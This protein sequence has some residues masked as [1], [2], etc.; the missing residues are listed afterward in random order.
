VAKNSPAYEFA[1]PDTSGNIVKLSDFKGK[2]VFM[3]FWFNRCGA[4]KE[5]YIYQLKGVEEKYRNNK[6]VVFV[7]VNIDVNKQVWLD[8]IYDNQH[9]SLDAINLYTEGLGADHP[10]IQN[11]KIIGYPRPILID[12]SG[13]LFSV[14][15]KDL[16][17]GK[18]LAELIDELLKS[19]AINQTD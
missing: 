12:Q 6:D 19:Q 4:C 10:I 15:S 7:T 18:K 8:G 9:T 3:D 1:L 5:Y 11:Y 2:V 17:N 16:L 14:I 13:K